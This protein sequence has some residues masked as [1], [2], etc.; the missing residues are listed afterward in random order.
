MSESEKEILK[1]NSKHLSDLDDKLFIIQYFETD[2][3]KI[4][5]FECGNDK[6]KA[7][8]WLDRKKIL[9]TGKKSKKV[10]QAWDTIGLMKQQQMHEAE[11]RDFQTLLEV[12]FDEAK[13]LGFKTRNFFAKEEADRLESQ[14][15]HMIPWFPILK[16][17]I[18]Y[19][20]T[21]GR[22][23]ERFIPSQEVNKVNGKRGGEQKGKY[24][25]ELFKTFIRNQR[26]NIDEYMTMSAENFL[27]VLKSKDSDF[28]L[29]KSPKTAGKYKKLLIQE[30]RLGK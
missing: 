25:Y 23:M 19:L 16:Q 20:R 24:K 13:Y 14:Q 29:F 26:M 10:V 2:K 21:V 6:I 4:S 17:W 8:A 3:V 28:N 15:G 30:W 7:Q 1:Q 11:I 18:E 5:L 9:N 27:I 12:K 22:K